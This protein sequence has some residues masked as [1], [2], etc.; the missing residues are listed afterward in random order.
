MLDKT[1]GLTQVELAKAVGLDK[2]TLTSQLDGLERQGL[3]VRR[4]DARDRRARVPELTDA[5]DQRRAEV[6]A[7]S[8]AA[9][10]EALSGFSVAD[11]AVFRRMLFE[12]IGTSADPGSCL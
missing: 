5:G 12:L 11:V 6:A 2:T 8:S 1:P 3:V 10:T 9:E 4:P 7:A